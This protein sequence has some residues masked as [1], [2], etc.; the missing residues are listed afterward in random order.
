M[1]RLEPLA[2][3]GLPLIHVVGDA[4]D[5]VP[6]AENTAIVE[7]RYRKLG[8]EMQVIHKPG[9]GHHPHGLDDC[10]PVVDWVKSHALPNVNNSS[11]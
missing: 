8:G 11:G 2:R 4:D 7:E 9:V 5:A 1:D 6:V 3:A 10:T